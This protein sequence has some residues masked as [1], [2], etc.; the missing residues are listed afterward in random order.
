[1]KD[2]VIVH[3]KDQEHDRRLEALLEIMEENRITLT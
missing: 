2:D 3:S 1:M